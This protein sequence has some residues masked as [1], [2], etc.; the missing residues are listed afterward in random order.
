MSQNMGYLTDTCCLWIRMLIL[1]GIWLWWTVRARHYVGCLLLL[2]AG[3]KDGSEYTH[4]PSITEQPMGQTL[5]LSTAWSTSSNPALLCQSS[6]TAVLIPP[7][8]SSGRLRPECHKHAAEHSS[9]SVQ[10]SSARSGPALLAWGFSC[11]GTY[12]EA[13][14]HRTFCLNVS[15]YYIFWHIQGPLHLF[16]TWLCTA[17]ICSRSQSVLT[18]V[19]LFLGPE[20]QAT[21]ND[22]YLYLYLKP[23]WTVS[24]SR[25]EAMCPSACARFHPWNPAWCSTKRR[26]LVYMEEPCVYM[27]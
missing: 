5:T 10:S 18:L 19:T 21:S 20:S 2:R 1:R 17:T 15:L 27:D 22:S 7:L 8:L 14:A 3:L 24:S 26:Y 6:K 9:S 11:S 23:S 12:K 16:L 13:F 4:S 25:T